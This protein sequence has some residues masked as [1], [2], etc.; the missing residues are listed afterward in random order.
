MAVK[1]NLVKEEQF[2]Q[3]FPA[4]NSVPDVLE[5][6]DNTFTFLAGY[7]DKEGITHKTFTLREP[8]GKDEEAMQR[9]LRTNPS[10]AI[11]T[12][13]ARICTSIGSLTRE[14]VGGMQNWEKIIKDLYI[15]DSDYMIYCARLVSFGEDSAIKVRHQCPECKAK[16][17]TEV[18]LNEI[19]ISEFK[20]SFEIPFT[21]PKGY[22]DRDGVIH[23]EGI[24]RLPKCL[25]RE[26]LYP[27]IK[28]NNTGKLNT[29]MLTRLCTFND[30]YR[31]DDDVM[32]HLVIRDRQYLD[33]LL[34]QN[35]FGIK[36]EVEVECPE[37]GNYFTVNLNLI[38]F[39]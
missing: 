17:D 6:E 21:L 12:L 8:N 39:I 14:S 31:V 7:T 10:K 26:I 34:E 16:L 18:P 9:D 30:G 19:G 13:L 1:K 32:G 29:L 22:K 36:T 3:E 15:G 23:R 27:I 5:E 35:M 20:G 33:E 28:K 2:E 37:C 24:L 25:D 11:T 38:N 4:P